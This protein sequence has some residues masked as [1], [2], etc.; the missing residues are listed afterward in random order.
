MY[1]YTVLRYTVLVYTTRTVHNV[2][3][4]TLKGTQL[5][6]SNCHAHA[7]MHEFAKLLKSTV[8]GTC[9]QCTR[10]HAGAGMRRRC[11]PGDVPYLGAHG[12]MD[13]WTHGHMNT[14]A[15]QRVKGLLAQ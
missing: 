6:T 12:H 13:T 10:S 14:R 11:A 8:H 4:P 9:I 7:C 15:H 1:T 3:T 2:Q 5:A